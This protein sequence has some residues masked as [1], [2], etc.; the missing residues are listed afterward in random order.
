[1]L[2]APVEV[3]N[4]PGARRSDRLAGRIVFDDVAFGYSAGKSVLRDVSF[5]TTPGQII[6]IFGL[7]GAGLVSWLKSMGYCFY[8]ITDQGL[9]ELE[10]PKLV[11]RFPFLFLSHLLSVRPKG[12]LAALF[13]RVREEAQRINLLETSK[14]F[15]KEE[16]PCLWQG[17]IP[18]G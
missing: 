7:T 6:G 11:K 9:F 2:D 10:A 1:M 18:G 13:E 4:K 5:E 3:A 12:E 14:H 15:P 16:W 8:P 17:R